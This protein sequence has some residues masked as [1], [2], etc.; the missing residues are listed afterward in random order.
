[1]R[2]L[3][4][5]LGV[6]FVS[7]LIFT[8][9]GTLAQ[10][11]KHFDNGKAIV[12]YSITVTKKYKAEI[13][14]VPFDPETGSIFTSPNQTQK[15]ELLDGKTIETVKE[16]NYE[17][18]YYYQIVSPGTYVVHSISAREASTSFFPTTIGFEV[19]PG[20]ALFLGDFAIGQMVTR[21]RS[22]ADARTGMNITLVNDDVAQSGLSSRAIASKGL[23]GYFAHIEN[24]QLI[25]FVVNNY[26]K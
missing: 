19:K 11:T 22:L 21:Y 7:G 6:F 26:N 3:V 16:G 1:M 20:Q 17:I 8:S 4:V 13:N 14:W 23:D 2:K 9:T 24:S 12:F 25:N 18:R 10:D 15:I 5:F